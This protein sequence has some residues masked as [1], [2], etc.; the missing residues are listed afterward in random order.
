MIYECFMFHNE[1]E[2]LALKLAHHNSHVDRFVII[3]SNVRSNQSPKPYLLEENW[4]MFAEYRNKIT[5]LKHDGVGLEPGWPTI[6][7]QRNLADKEITFRDSDIVLISDLDEFLNEQ[8]FKSMIEHFAEQSTD[9]RFLSTCYWCFA[10]LRHEKSQHT[11]AAVL[12]NK[13]RRS[14]THRHQDIEQAG[15]GMDPSVKILSGGIHLSWFGN[16]QQFREKIL[17]SIEGFKYTNS[18]ENVA[19]HWNQKS[20]GKLFSEKVKFKSTRLQKVPLHDNSDFTD[21]MKQYIIK[22]P[23]W[24]LSD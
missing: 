6:N 22:N 2:M 5:Y 15:Q 7:D 18:G 3:E 13:L 21:E 24:I 23:N 1:L 10:N 19:W 14:S 12:G 4:H 20:K 17:G 8:D 11:I 9:L 16:E